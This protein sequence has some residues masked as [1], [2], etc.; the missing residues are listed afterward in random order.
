M[1]NPIHKIPTITVLLF[2]CLTAV[3]GAN[4]RPIVDDWVSNNWFMTD[5]PAIA[6]DRYGLPFVATA[7]PG[8]GRA[9]QVTLKYMADGDSTPRWEA[10]DFDFNWDTDAGAS[11]PALATVRN[12][13]GII[14]V[15]WSENDKISGAAHKQVRIARV[16]DDW[17][18]TRLAD[19]GPGGPIN[20][21]QFSDASN[22]AM[23]IIG[24]DLYVAWSEKGPGSPS[25][26]YVARYNASRDVFEQIGTGG[27]PINHNKDR[28]A[29]RP[30]ISAAGKK[31]VV[32][33]RE[34]DGA[35]WE[36]R[37][38]I[39]NGGGSW[40]ELDGGESPINIDPTRDAGSASL[41]TI[42]GVV[43][44]AWAENSGASSQI[45]VARFVRGS[46]EVVSNGGAPLNRDAT[47]D[48]LDATL[49]NI[50]NIPFVSWREYDGSYWQAR[51]ARTSKDV[52]SGAEKWVPVVDEDR[53]INT[54]LSSD[55]LNLRMANLN[56][57]P[58]VVWR[59][60]LYNAVYVKRLVPD[61]FSTKVDPGRT[62]ASVSAVI[63]TYG[64]SWPLWFRYHLR[65]SDKYRRT[66]TSRTSNSTFDEVNVKI[67]GLKPAS[68]YLYRTS[69]MSG[70]SQPIFHIPDSE[71][72][73]NTRP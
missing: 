33:W 32:A 59:E 29:E 25:Q 46:W 8:F 65:N 53:P 4:W 18:V 31:P 41:A 17:A 71:L 20:Y 49:V 47:K 55:A 50:G 14:Y 15:A 45:W 22:P 67:K 23:T 61:L 26:I 11:S 38:A 2:I 27:S 57:A 37:A 24:K 63:N 56:G 3:A 62:S 13:T 6:G 73:F 72:S 21:D 68:T 19:G 64:V 42:N 5:T 34:F 10:L 1:R 30:S 9:A 36:L 39:F 60:S 66:K 35:N 54:Y 28:D 16:E 48:A 7:Q 43:Y 52:A 58:F 40:Q 44:I 69:G 12:G 70:P 51:V